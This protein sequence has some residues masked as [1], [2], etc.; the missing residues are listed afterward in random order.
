VGELAKKANRV[1]EQK[2]IIRERKEEKS[3][4]GFFINDLI[5][6]S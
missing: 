5:T 4:I 2:W 6:F 3:M 1:V